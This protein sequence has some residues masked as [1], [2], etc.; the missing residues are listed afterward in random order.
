MKKN[1]EQN[2]SQNLLVRATPLKFIPTMLV[3]LTIVWAIVIA[4]GL[5]I[6]QRAGAIGFTLAWVSIDNSFGN[7]DTAENSD[8]WDAK[9]LEN[10][11]IREA[12]YN[13]ESRF[14]RTMATNKGAWLLTFFGTFLLMAA[15][16]KTL[17]TILFAIGKEIVK[18]MSQ[19]RRWRLRRMGIKRVVKQDFINLG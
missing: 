10:Q 15:L 12:L 11:K 9:Y 5:P 2:N 14:V 8:R 13:S 1:I 7:R 3:T 6:F 17:F 19:K 18:E 4:I 16:T